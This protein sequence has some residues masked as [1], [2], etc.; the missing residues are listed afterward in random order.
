MHLVSTS[1]SFQSLDEFLVCLPRIRGSTS[2]ERKNMAFTPSRCGSAWA[3][4]SPV[5]CDGN[6]GGV[7]DRWMLLGALSFAWMFAKARRLF[8]LLLVL[9]RTS[10]AP[11]PCLH[12]TSFGE[13][14]A[15]ACSRVEESKGISIKKGIPQGSR[16]CSFGLTRSLL[17]CDPSMLLRSSTT[18]KT[19]AFSCSMLSL[20]LGEIFLW[21]LLECF[22]TKQ[23]MIGW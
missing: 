19:C 13:P 8:W 23:R 22:G 5:L 9:S 6:T 14:S 10:G 4:C 20:W 15:I 21:K 11:A 16:T 3:V 17:R 7:N 18:S 12:V 1:T 2:T